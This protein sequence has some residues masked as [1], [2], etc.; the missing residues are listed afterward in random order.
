MLSVPHSAAG[1]PVGEE[2]DAATPHASRVRS[3]AGSPLS[4]A[5]L[6]DLGGQRV[7]FREGSL[8]NSDL[9][10]A[11]RGPELRVEAVE[12]VATR[13]GLDFAELR[14]RANASRARAAQLSRPAR[15]ARSRGAQSDSSHPITHCQPLEDRS[16]A[17]WCPRHTSPSRDQSPTPAPAPRPRHPRSS[18]Q[19]T[20]ESTRVSLKP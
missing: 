12:R 10:W 3:L 13:R 7:L 20:P 11:R 2:D 5:A 1:P 8:A 6:R 14:E 9:D 16:D 18:A 15:S 17:L 4:T 19:G